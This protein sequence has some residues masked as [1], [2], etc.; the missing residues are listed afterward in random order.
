MTIIRAKIQ[1]A[2]TCVGTVGTEEEVIRTICAQSHLD[3]HPAECSILRHVNG[4][5]PT[6]IRYVMTG[7]VLIGSYSLHEYVLIETMPNH[8][9]GSHRAAGNFGTYPANGSVREWRNAVEA[10][11]L[12]ENDPDGYNR[13]VKR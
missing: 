2:R 5:G 8:L 3:V 7:G 10:E 4:S 12:V 9:R 11:E 1:S 6:G 13:I